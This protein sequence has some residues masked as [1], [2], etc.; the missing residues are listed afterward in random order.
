MRLLLSA[1]VIS[2]RTLVGA[3]L[4]LGVAGKLSHLKDFRKILAAYDIV[5]TSTVPSVSLFL[6]CLE[7]V[8]G[9]GIFIDR[10]SPFAALLAAL[11][12][13]LLAVAVAFNLLRGRTALRCGCFG[14][15]TKMISWGL[16]A[17][18]FSLVAVACIGTGFLTGLPLGLAF[19]SAI[20]FWSVTLFRSRRRITTPEASR[21]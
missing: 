15:A 7:L 8:S 13:F 19:G 6:I 21:S 10:F 3:V 20:L 9:I 18:D 1:L 2:C 17:R 16:V 4:F 12:F 5:P 11:V 14:K